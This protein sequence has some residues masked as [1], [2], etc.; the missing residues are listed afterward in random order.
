MN[1]VHGASYETPNGTWRKISVML[2]EGDWKRLEFE[3]KVP[4]EGVTTDQKFFLMSAFAEILLYKQ[5]Y[6]AGAI[7]AESAVG[8]IKELQARIEKLV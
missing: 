1:V 4:T 5:L 8:K 2:D 6:A 3:G 7:P